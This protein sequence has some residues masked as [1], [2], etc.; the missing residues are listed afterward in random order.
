MGPKQQ[1]LPPRWPAEG[2][3]A[4]A[5]AEAGCKQIKDYYEPPHGAYPAPHEPAR[6]SSWPLADD[7]PGATGDVP[8][9][10]RKGVVNVPFP[11]RMVR[12]EATKQMPVMH[13]N[14][15]EGI[16]ATKDK[17]R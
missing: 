6:M 7:V 16:W 9:A 14:G 2:V 8:G 17:K 13:P 5:V 4:K 1:Q 15:F 11:H 12:P 3:E 10:A